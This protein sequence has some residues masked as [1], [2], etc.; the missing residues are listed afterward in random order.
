MFTSVRSKLITLSLLLV[1]VAVIPVVIA[2]NILINNAVHDSHRA[3]V[4]HQADIIEQ[5]LGVFYDD[6][7][8]NID[9]F[10]TH[11]KVRAADDSITSYVNTPDKV[12]I[13]PSR[14][15]GIEQEIYEAFEHYAQTHPG[16]MYVYMATE[17]GAYVQWPETNVHKAYDPRQKAWYKLAMA[18]NGK[19][20]RTDPYKDTISG[21][22]IVSNVRSF[23]DKNG[24][25]YGMVGIDVSSAK[26]SEI[27][28]RIHI[29]KTGYAMMVHKT[30]V[31]L[32]DP[33]NKENNLKT[34]K[35]TGIQHLET[36][37]ER[38]HA[39]FETA[40]ND[41]EY[42]VDSFQ[43]DISDWVVVALVEKGELAQVASHIRTIVLGITLLVLTL[44][45]LLSWVLSGRFIRP[46]NLMVAGLK[47]IAEGDGDLTMRLDAGGKDELSEMARWF[48]TFVQKLQGIITDIAGDAKELDASSSGLLSISGEVSGGVEKMSE[49]SN[50]VAAA[51]EEMSGNM[52]SVTAAV[53][54]SASNIGMVS[55]AAE[56]MTST[57]SEIAKSTAQ[58]RTTSHDA[59][60]RTHTASGQ[61]S[62]LSR[63]ARE[64]G[65]VVETITDIS[66]QTNL[67]ALNAT[68][69]AA[70]AGSAG[71]G[72]AVVAGEIKELARQTAGAT[73][74]IKEKIQNIQSATGQTVTEIEAVA[75]GI[76]SV[77]EMIDT[78]AAAVEEQSAT[79]R[80]IAQ[81]VSQA[82][83]GIHEVT[84]KITL[85][86]AVAEEIS[87]EIKEVSEAAALISEN[88][89]RIDTSAGGLST[90]SGK[91][92][93]TVHLFRI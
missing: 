58:T 47:D 38:K 56:E 57:I 68:I 22:L 24:R 23:K 31:I 6:L 41:R 90:L 44:A 30:G 50:R 76:S 77:N 33:R 32:A 4:A 16:T 43:S 39:S 10:A 19:V 48:N 8:R 46:I 65:N 83:S 66:E 52:A 35:E 21:S 55:A 14:N 13:T 36:V 17:D 70:R 91:L 34:V 5:M 29:G 67:L 88:S 71:K 49:K 79:T 2:V 20:Q 62:E 51:A 89:T 27:M 81:N 11:P 59:V 15:G 73:L 69:E 82:A 93:E 25:D 64:I 3:N 54:Q 37:L 80:E 45:G 92:K 75:G 60:A 85:S 7:D 42:Q 72:F 86:S 78:V 9:L 87:A 63:S 18:G 61:I 1:L 12:K 84:E 28:E 40:V 53:E 74:E 26:L